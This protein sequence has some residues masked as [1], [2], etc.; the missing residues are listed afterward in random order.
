MNHPIHAKEYMQIHRVVFSH[1]SG[2][3]H[4][5]TNLDENEITHHHKP[6]LYRIRQDRNYQSRNNVDKDGCK[7]YS[8]YPRHT[9]WPRQDV[10]QS[11]R[12]P[13]IPRS[14]RR[15]HSKVC[16]CE[17][18]TQTEDRDRSEHSGRTIRRG[19]PFP[20]A[21]YEVKPLVRRWFSQSKTK[22]WSR[23]ERCNS[24][25]AQ[26]PEKSKSTSLLLLIIITLLRKD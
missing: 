17:H 11:S 18:N 15:S 8:K 12:K 4:L 22:S 10:S 26:K 1:D 3:P 25:D 16:R 2:A 19:M 5:L 6:T 23:S 24:R 9:M 13:E 7:N 14:Y 21:R 20:K